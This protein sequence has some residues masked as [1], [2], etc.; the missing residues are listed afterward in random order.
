MRRQW[1]RRPRPLRRSTVADCAKTR[2]ITGISTVPGRS[3]H[4]HT[5]LTPTVPEILGTVGAQS[6]QHET[7]LF[8]GF[9]HRLCPTVPDCAR[10][11]PAQWRVCVRT[12]PYR[13]VLTLVFAVHTHMAG[14]S[15]AGQSHRQDNPR[16]GGNGGCSGVALG[17]ARRWG[18]LSSWWC[19]EGKGGG[20][21]APAPRR[22]LSRPEHPN[23]DPV[24][25]H[26]PPAP[27]RT[28][29]MCYTLSAH[30]DRATPAVFSCERV[31]VL[32]T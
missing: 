14:H 31:L 3:G 27:R 12:H 29:C 26:A 1:S 20:L 25:Q 8:S 21:N 32:Y 23:V 18:S 19:P 22:A 11:C 9:Y 4:T 28:R 7:C 10:L 30:V 13:G 24:D 17:D 16:W 2:V 6:K 5:S 15:R